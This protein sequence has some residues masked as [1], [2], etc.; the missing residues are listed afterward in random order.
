[1]DNRD[2][3]MDTVGSRLTRHPEETCIAHV[4]L[5]GRFLRFNQRFA[6]ITGYS[7]EELLNL[8]FQEITHPDDL[9]TDIQYARRL[10]DGDIPTYSIE[11]RYLRKDGSPVWVRLT[12]SVVRNDQGAPQYFVAVIEDIEALRKAHEES[13]R[14]LSQLETVLD[15]MTGGLVVADLEGNVYHWNRAAL[16]MHGYSSM[17][18]CCRQLQEFRDSYEFTELSGEVV[19][20]DRW[21]MMRIL[22]GEQLRNLELRIKRRGIGWQRVYSYSG[23]LARDSSGQPLL[24]VLNIDDITERKRS[25]E[26]LQRFR[27]LADNSRDIM[28]FIRRHDGQILDANH[29]AAKAYGYSR[30]E[31]LSLTIHNLRAACTAGQTEAQMAKADGDG[32]LFETVHR[33]KDG[34]TFPAEVNSQGATIGGERILVSVIRD[35]T[36]RKRYEEELLKAKAAAEAANQ[37]KSQFLANMSHEIRTPMTVFLGALEQLLQVVRQPEHREL[38][39]LADQSAQRLYVLINDILDFSKIEANRVQV[40]EEPF[41][42]QLCIQNTLAMMGPKAREKALALEMNIPSTLPRYLVGDQYR[43]EQVLINLIGNAIK[44]TEQGTVIVAAQGRED[45]LE[46]TVSD[47][48]TGIPEDKQ[49]IIFQTFSQADNSSTRRF[50]GTGL[51]LAICKGLV[52]L[53]G[54]KIGVLSKPGLGSVFWFTLPMKT[55]VRQKAET[56]AEEGNAL[57]KGSLEVSILLVEDNPMVSDVIQKIL[58]RRSW[59]T[60]AAETGRD[61]VRK[62]QEG[63]F[64][65]V[66]MD[67]QMPDM[68]GL[69]AT[70]RIRELA[71]RRGK[72]VDIIGLTAHTGSEIHEQCRAAGMND[73]LVKPFE[74]AKLY[75]TIERYLAQQP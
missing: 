47:T 67:L 57:E 11:K 51:G 27:L 5:D 16:K 56:L 44:F 42:L 53:M 60:V 12:G 41:D 69:E 20:F 7:E 74:S 65:I 30:D 48:G 22:Q 18:Q 62:W 68:D 40:E 54:G 1:M 25:E 21:P 55:A 4:G 13:E 71:T 8:T 9:E 31:L 70:R 36:E 24:A 2:W 75:A 6:A 32:I 39:T 58:S 26:V 64:D 43:F 61:A 59:K 28:F 19:P 50:G 15:S 34:S 63:D 14:H 38:L 49:A 23:A 35:I 17:E 29:A 37:A 66:L 33:R 3:H 72:Q 73:V 45:A 10:T 46:F 52:E